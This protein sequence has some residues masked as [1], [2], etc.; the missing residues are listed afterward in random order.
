MSDF[1][2][3]VVE[4]PSVRKHENADTLSIV[5]IFGNPV[6]IRT[7]DYTPGQ[8][9]AYIPVDSVVPL[10]SPLFDFL[11]DPNKPTKTHTRIK[12]KKLRG[13]Y[14]EGMLVPADPAWEIGSDVA[15][16]L[17][18]VKYEEPE[19]VAS[20]SGGAERDPGFMP[21]YDVEPYRK[22]K[23][24]LDPNEM[25]VVTE[26]LHGCNARFCWNTCLTCKGEGNIEDPNA[27]EGAFFVNVVLCPDCNGEGA[28]LYVASH[29]QV[30]R[31]DPPVCGGRSLHRR[32]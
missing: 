6:V 7:E 14:S 24:V 19:Q 15:P 5:E 28:R 4:L 26:K 2:V 17:G 1:R 11:K 23:K 8:K 3:E 12:A 27:P 10:D 30:K 32:I 13:Q 20:T 9:V 22:W 31:A 29:K 18:V 25:V 21:V 16:L